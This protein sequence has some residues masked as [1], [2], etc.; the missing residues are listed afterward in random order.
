MSYPRKFPKLKTL[1][2]SS[3]MACW[4]LWA[5]I[6][7]VIIAVLF[8]PILLKKKEM[9]GSEPG[10]DLQ[11]AFD[12]ILPTEQ[13]EGICH[14]ACCL[15]AQWPTPFDTNEDTK[16]EFKEK[17]SVQCRSCENGIGCL[18]KK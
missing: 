18:C 9:F 5:G 6:A 14:P 10:A 13:R 1:P 4:Q 12:G 17:T 8:L 3:M 2:E 15:T 11:R 16:A 7:I